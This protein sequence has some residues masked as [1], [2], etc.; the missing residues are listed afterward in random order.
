MPTGRKPTPTSL[1]VLNGNPGKRPLPKNEPKPTPTA[2]DCPEWLSDNAK[3]EW[4]RIAPQLEKLG[5][6][7]Q[8]D[9]TALAAY[10]ESWALYKDCTEY[11]HK[12]GYSY[13]LFERDKDGEI[14]R[15]S[16]GKPLLKYMQQWPQVSIANKA[17]MQVRAF[18]TEFGLTPSSRGRLQVP[19]ASEA[20]ELDGI[21]SGLK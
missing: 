3:A 19:G 21:L 13:P 16:H 11:I 1:K 10:C 5:L 20:N 15:D 12:N 9:Q 6:L 2:P 4:Q 17:L 7:T 8:V 18:C 14:K